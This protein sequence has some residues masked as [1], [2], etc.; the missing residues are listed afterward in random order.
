MENLLLQIKADI[1]SAMLSK[2]AKKKLI[3]ST[4]VGEI[5]R[6][7]PIIVDG[8]K[9]HTD[10]QI[11]SVIKKMIESNKVTGTIDENEYLN[12]Y[13]PS[14]LSYDELY[15]IIKNFIVN[16]SLSGLKDTGKVMNYLKQ[17]FAGKYDG[18]TAATITKS[19]L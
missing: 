5:D 6:I 16:N 18:T 14:E 19:E 9:T 2:D 12:V 1:K 11:I 10:I 8:L 17:N 4:L 15:D 3:L 13:L 7:E